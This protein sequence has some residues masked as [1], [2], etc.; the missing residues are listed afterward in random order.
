MTEIIH[1]ISCL[2]GN[3]FILQAENPIWKQINNPRPEGPNENEK[4]P[5]AK[6]NSLQSR[7]QGPL[8]GEDPVEIFY[9]LPKHAER[10]VMENLTIAS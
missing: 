8:L 10:R 5:I 9:R 6:D 2:R 4:P 7:S 3:S 1:C